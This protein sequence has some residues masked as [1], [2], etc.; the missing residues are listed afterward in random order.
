MRRFLFLLALA[1]FV[2]AVVA[3]ADT[4]LVPGERMDQ[5]VEVRDVRMA[6]DGTVTGVVANRSDHALRD[7]RLRVDYEFLWDKERSPGAVSPG[8]IETADV[9]GPIRP[10]GTA[11]FTHAP[12]EPLPARNDGRFQPHVDVSDATMLEEA[13]ALR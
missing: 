10:G 4:R 9:P 12:S 5:I 2:L 8:R 13:P 11:E 1:P 6:A 3:R 7:L